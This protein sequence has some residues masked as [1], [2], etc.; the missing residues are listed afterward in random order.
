M[1]ED[2]LGLD[3]KSPENLILLNPRWPQE[4]YQ[5]LQ[6]L[7]ETVQ[8]DRGLTHHVWIATSGSTADSIGST[9]LVALSKTALQASAESV[10]KHLQANQ[11]D[12]WTQVLPHFHV[13]GLGIEIRAQLS[14]S[15]VV[16]A[17]NHGKWDP[18]Y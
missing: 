13:G 3:L 16:K 15:Q 1:A 6:T 14:G 12:V 18:E 4:D 17:L 2:Q 5:K 7:A 8:A 10:N 9:K 11:N